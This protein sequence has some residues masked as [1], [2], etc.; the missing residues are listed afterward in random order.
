MKKDEIEEY[1]RAEAI[2]RGKFDKDLLKIIVDGQLYP[3][4][5]EFCRQVSQTMKASFKQQY[6]TQLIRDNK[7][8]PI[9]PVVCKF[10]FLKHG[11]PLNL[12]RQDL[13]M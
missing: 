12:I 2:R 10:L 3:S 7:P 8:R 9:P 1:C 11:I 13:Y 4:K 6:L 5:S